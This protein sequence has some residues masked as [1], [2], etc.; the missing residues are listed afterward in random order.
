MAAGV[1]KL[2]RR[3]DSGKTRQ[4]SERATLFVHNSTNL[5]P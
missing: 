4:H 1:L 2:I 3:F 5:G